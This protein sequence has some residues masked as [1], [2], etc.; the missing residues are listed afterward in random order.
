[1]LQVYAGGFT[2]TFGTLTD[3]TA[4]WA[5]PVL[6]VSALILLGV[7]VGWLVKQAIV[8]LLNFLRIR[9]FTESTGLDKIFSVRVSW[10]ALLGDIAQWTIIFVFL[11]WALSIFPAT[12]GVQDLVKNL[13]NYLPQVFGAVVIVLI[14][15]VVADLLSRF[16]ENAAKVLGASTASFLGD[17]AKYAVLVTVFLTA[18]VQ[19]GVRQEFLTTLYS[20]LV[21]G[22][23]GAFILAFGLG[24]Q[25][26]ASDVISRARTNWPKNK[27]K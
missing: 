1:M 13:I 18:L 17:I 22:I 11:L 16:V 20:A 2:D 21:W 23:A 9:R 8:N 10:A 27:R 25:S 14:G 6:T 24:G 7:L 19:L 3:R 26:S 15:A 12:S 4:Q 5:L